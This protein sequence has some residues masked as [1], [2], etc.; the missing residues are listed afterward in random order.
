MPDP[1]FINVKCLFFCIEFTNCNLFSSEKSQFLGQL[2]QLTGQLMELKFIRHPTN[3]PFIRI[4]RN[5]PQLC[6]FTYIPTGDAYKDLLYDKEPIIPKEQHDNNML[7]SQ[8]QFTFDSLTYLCLDV[9]MH[10]RRL[11]SI[12]EKCHNL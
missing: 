5:C 11:E 6:R 10:K 9:Y 4:L 8:E 2:K 3:L 1:Q 12:V 7:P